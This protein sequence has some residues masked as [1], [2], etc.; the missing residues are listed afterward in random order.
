MTGARGTAD[1]FFG[2]AGRVALVS[3][4]RG[5]IG[6]AVTRRL[7]GVGARVVGIDLP[8][9]GQDAGADTLECDL[10]EP[11]AVGRMFEEL[12]RGHDR[13]DALVHCAGI[14]RDNVLWKMSESDWS[15]VLRSNLD[16]A[17]LL[18]RHAIP[19]MRAG[20][21]GSIVLVSSINGE[22]GKFGQAN[23]A[24]SKAGLLG[25]ARTA[26]RETGRFGIR[27]NVVAPGMID[28][29]M[30]ARLG[31][32]VRRQAIEESA[33]GAIGR[34]EDVADAVLYLASAM[35]RHVTGQVLRV[36]GG[37]LTA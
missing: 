2:L 24:A 4:A 11:A 31:A 22:R 9:T 37:Q 29:A 19:L 20:G 8:R 30:T 26:A 32:D 18:L 23:Y 21:G 14:T 16:S 13:L 12:R 1:D 25:L 35:S 15:D 34:P 36:D 5:G 28:T 3:G 33:L 7:A 6:T 17:F 10:G 27:V